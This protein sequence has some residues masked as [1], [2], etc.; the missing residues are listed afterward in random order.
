MATVL[1]S[2]NQHLLWDLMSVDFG[3]LT[4]RSVHPASPVLL[5]KWPTSNP[6]FCVR[7]QIEQVGLLTYLK[8]ENRSRSFF[9]TS[10][11]SLYLIN[12]FGYSYPEGT[13]EGTSY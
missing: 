2:V 3:T 9:D 7:L 13:S 11:H 8:F 12:C 4:R 10:N 5:K 1:L 6:A